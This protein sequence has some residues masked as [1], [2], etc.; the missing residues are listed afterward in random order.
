MASSASGR[1]QLDGDCRNSSLCR[2]TVLSICARTNSTMAKATP[3]AD[4]VMRLLV[5]ATA[6]TVTTTP[7]SSTVARERRNW[8]GARSIMRKPITSRMPASVATGIQGIRRL[9]SSAATSAKTPVM[10]P[11][12]RVVAPLPR[13]TRVAP[14]WP[15][16]DIPP[17]PLHTTFATPWPISSRLGSCRLRVNWSSTTQVLRVSI[18][19]RA[20]R[21]NAALATPS[22]SSSRRWVMPDQRVASMD[23]K[24]SPAIASEPMTSPLPPRTRSDGSINA[25]AP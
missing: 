4:A 25:K 13:P 15:A 2:T 20:A 18:E 17:R 11:V 10:T 1:C 5:S 24:P 7:K 22:T 6:T 14:I 8:S 21:V 9:N 12:M 19:S 23:R 16:P 3:A